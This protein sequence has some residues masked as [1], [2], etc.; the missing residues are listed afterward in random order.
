MRLFLPLL[1]LL[2]GGAMAM[3]GRVFAEAVWG[4]YGGCLYVRASVAAREEVDAIVV[5]VKAGDAEEVRVEVTEGGEAAADDVV[6]LAWRDVL[7]IRVRVGGP[8][9]ERH[10]LRVD[11]VSKG[12]RVESMP[13]SGWYAVPASAGGIWFV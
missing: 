8:G 12:V 7:E 1:A 11:A 13:R 2:A 3:H 6:A 4:G 5:W 9:D 10:Q